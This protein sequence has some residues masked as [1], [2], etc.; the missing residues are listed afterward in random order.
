[1]HRARLGALAAVAA[2]AVVASLATGA[3]GASAQER[4]GDHH[5]ATA[6]P[7]KHLVVIFQENVSFDHY[8]GTYPNAANTGGQTFN[9]SSHTP[10]VDGLTPAL[11]TANPNGVNPRR[12]DPTNVNDVLTCDQD[13]N[14]SDEQKAFDN[15]AMDKFPQ[16]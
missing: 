16:T 11:L 13:H 15:G 1:M 9:A 7:I 10:S 2:T 5:S 14:Y 12:Y 3:A 4:H 8:F 6:T